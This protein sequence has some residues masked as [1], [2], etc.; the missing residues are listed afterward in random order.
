LDK[1][2]FSSRRASPSL[3]SVGAER[4]ASLSLTGFCIAGLLAGCLYGCAT[5][6]PEPLDI[7]KTAQ[8]FDS[9]SMSNAGLCQYLNTNPY[10]KLSSCPPPQWNLA[11]LTLMG[12]YYSPDMAVADA[13]VSE[14]DAAVITARGVPNPTAHLGPQFREAIS[15][16]FAPWGIGSFNLD[17]PIE[18]AGKRGYRTAEAQRLA[19][20]ARLAAGETAWGVRSRIRA[21]LLQ[22]LLEPSRTRSVGA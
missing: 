9:R 11:A 18:T 2:D 21:A 15:P 22:Y 13:R 16:N 6:H 5:Y 20:A 1:L 7:V 12:F 4:T 19:D 14:A 17:L 8:H 10:T 3:S